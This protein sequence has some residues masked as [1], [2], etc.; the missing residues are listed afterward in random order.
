[1]GAELRERYHSR[2][3]GVN[4]TTY[5]NLPTRREEGALMGAAG[6]A[7]ARLRGGR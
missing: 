6:V 4:S 2:I 1:M 3:G 5:V 7:E